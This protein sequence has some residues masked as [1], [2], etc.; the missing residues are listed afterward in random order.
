M[1]YQ[2]L[3]SALVAGSFLAAA[4]CLI[5]Q[6]AG[7]RL[8]PF[9][10]ALPG[11]IGYLGEPDL[12]VYGYGTSNPVWLENGTIYATQFQGDFANLCRWYLDATTRKVRLKDVLNVGGSAWCISRRG[13]LICAQFQSQQRRDRLVT[14]PDHLGLFRADDGTCLWKL[15]VG[16]EEHFLRCTF[17]SDESHLALLSWREQ[18][19]SLRLIDTQKGVVIRRH[20]FDGVDETCRAQ[21]VARSSALWVRRADGRVLRLP[22]ETLVPEDVECPVSSPGSLYVSSDEQAISIT[23]EGSC[24]ILRRKGSAWETVFEDSTFETPGGYPEG[25]V[26]VSFSPDN[27]QAVV[28]QAVRLRVIDLGSGKVLQETPGEFRHG[29]TFS[30]EGH[31]LLTAEPPG[32]SVRSAAT[33]KP[34]S[35]S[36]LH[37]HRHAAGPLL[38]LPG[39]RTLASADHEG[40]WLWDLATRSPIAHLG[41]RTHEEG[42]L[43]SLALAGNGRAIIAD[44]WQNFL[45]W[46]L[47]PLEPLKAG[48][49]PPEIPFSPAFGALVEDGQE[50][51]TGK[52]FASA[53]GK[54]IVTRTA[55]RGEFTLRTGLGARTSTAFPGPITKMHLQQGVVSDDGKTFVYGHPL[56]QEYLKADLPSGQTTTFKDRVTG[57]ATTA[58]G[59]PRSARR[60]E[61][62]GLL[63]DARRYI[64]FSGTNF[65]VMNLDGKSG[66]VEMDDLPKGLDASTEDTRMPLSSSALVVRLYNLHT[67]EKYISIWD[68]GTGKLR[69]LQLIPFDDIHA[70]AM[71]PD[72]N[73]LLC[74]HTH[75]AI[76]LWDVSKMSAAL[77]TPEASQETLPPATAQAGTLPVLPR[78]PNIRSDKY[79]EGGPWLFSDAGTA[80]K[81][82]HLPEAGRLRV[83]GNDFTHQAWQLTNGYWLGRYFDAQ[84]DLQTEAKRDPARVLQP[85]VFG[86]IGAGL[87]SAGEGMA[88]SVWVSRQIGNPTAY[89]DPFL[90]F[91][92]TLHNQDLET[93]RKEI[94]FEV[95]FPEGSGKLIDSSFKTVQVAP[96]GRANVDPDAIWVAPIMKEGSTDPIPALIFR[97]RSSSHMPRIEWMA[98]ENRLVVR[99]DVE[100][101]AAEPRHLVH[102]ILMIP[103]APGGSPE[104]FNPPRWVDFS[105]AVPYS[106][107]LRGLNFAVLPTGR[108]DDGF[109]MPVGLRSPERSLG[110]MIYKDPLGFPWVQ[111]RDGSFHGQLGASSV[112][113][114]RIADIP[115]CFAGSHLFT[116]IDARR[117]ESRQPDSGEYFGE[118]LEQQLQVA[119]ARVPQYGKEQLSLM[120]DRFF[121]RSKEPVTK[122]VTYVSTFSE[123][124]K[125]IF[126]AN[127]QPLAAGAELSLEKTQGALIFEVPGEDRPATLVAFHEQGAALSPKLSMPTPKM[128]KIEY[129]ITIPP[130]QSVTLWHGTTQRPLGSFASV[131][132]AFTGCL[133]LKR[134]RPEEPLINGSNVK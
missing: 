21:L 79:G 131:E 69:A 60:Y 80:S 78:S 59:K 35:Q 55:G 39:G 56:N 99:H 20:D 34:L 41:S 113:Q 111:N 48:Q 101:P 110:R 36:T 130:L 15:P 26:G 83:G 2:S 23:S 67:Q 12:G 107:N 118:D 89:G 66:L 86:K 124:V 27:R 5:A 90:I 114:L 53:D 115:L 14:K 106:E 19:L 132:E 18:R 93:A 22:V 76:S 81:G 13:D 25:F 125:Q 94:E 50:L 10:P 120:S 3:L 122:Q 119:R 64:G 112:L 121:N 117:E 62:W 116:M 4:P 29:T 77:P 82:A 128:L 28:S 133:P 42:A 40:I 88:G 46:Q 92:D 97:S 37:Q 127:G 84:H 7:H 49:E 30:P 31:S 58:D 65:C 57:S 44:D 43:R 96:D 91:T 87:I 73:T 98:A 68:L 61:F 102:A 100:L 17:T 9:K 70:H 105:L 33:L 71:S 85:T 11:L 129:E 8:E 95:R 54:V 126:A 6:D 38:V 103:R 16:P 123:P 134:R 108:L 52:V 51:P 63:P 45:A 1:Q 104:H 74:S 32:F 47:P 109:E 75:G 72:G 24:T